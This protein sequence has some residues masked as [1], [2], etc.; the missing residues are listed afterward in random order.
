MQGATASPRPRQAAIVGSVMAKALLLAMALLVW[1]AV[2]AMGRGAT[3]R[4]QR[5]QEGARRRVL[6]FMDGG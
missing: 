1:I 4:A 3:D 6:D 5:A 2:R